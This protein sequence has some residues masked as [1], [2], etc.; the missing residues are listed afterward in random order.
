[1]TIYCLAGRSAAIAALHAYLADCSSPATRFAFV[2]SRLSVVPNQIPQI[3]NIL[4]ISWASFHR[5]GIRS[6]FGWYR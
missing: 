1:M 4:A 2:L 5:G 3:T 6:K